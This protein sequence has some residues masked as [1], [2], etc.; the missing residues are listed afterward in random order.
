MKRPS[1]SDRQYLEDALHQLRLEH[2]AID[3][4]PAGDNTAELRN[5][6]KRI[7]ELICEADCAYAMGHSIYKDIQEIDGLFM[8]LVQGAVKKERERSDS[9]EDVFI[10]PKRR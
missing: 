9:D 10:K 8:R 4:M 7:R 1:E 5:I 6:L 2:E 3:R